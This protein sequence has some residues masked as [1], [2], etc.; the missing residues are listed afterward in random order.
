M[1]W[2]FARTLTGVWPVP[3]AAGALAGCVDISGGAVELSWGITKPNGDIVRDCAGVGLA[4][5]RLEGYAAPGPCGGPGTSPAFL[6]EWPCSEFHGSTEFN[7][8]EGRYC[9]FITPVCANVADTPSASVPSPIVRQITLGEVA[10]LNA[11][12]IVTDDTGEACAPVP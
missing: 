9:M 8:A 1:T 6:A 12:L 7:I 10:Q 11:L 2:I 4:K 5:V 3:L